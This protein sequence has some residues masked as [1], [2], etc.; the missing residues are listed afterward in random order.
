MEQL[1]ERRIQDLFRH[2]ATKA[3][4]KGKTTKFKLTQLILENAS[5][6]FIKIQDIKEI[7]D[8]RAKQDIVFSEFLYFS[9]ITLRELQIL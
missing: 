7:R 4:D 6:C 2:I 8:N 1:T 9:C 3:I 5:E